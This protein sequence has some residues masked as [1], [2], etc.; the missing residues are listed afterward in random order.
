MFLDKI[1]N[2]Q[3]E[4]IQGINYLKRSE[5]PLVL[6]GTDIFADS[7]RK[8]LLHNKITVDHVVVNEEY[9]IP[10]SFF[11]DHKIE[12]LKDLLNLYPKVNLVIAS[13]A[14][15]KGLSVELSQNSFIN[16]YFFYDPTMF[17]FDFDDYYNIV[18]EYAPTLENFYLQLADDHSR[19][20]MIAFINTK[21]SGNPDSLVSLNIDGE[22]QYFPEFLQLREDE[23]FVDCGAFDG[24]TILDFINKTKGK[25]S[26]IYAFEPDKINIEKLEQ[27]ISPFKNI[28]IIEK[29]CFS[30]RNTLRFQDNEGISSSISNQ[31]NVIIEV[32]AI[33]NI[34]SG[35]VTYI[36]MDIEGSELEALKGAQKTIRTNLPRL[37]VSLYH[38]T[39][40]FFSIPQYIYE[41]NDSYQFYLR[42]YG[43]SSCELV[44][45]AIPYEK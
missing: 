38:R 31:G 24:D 11:Y 8:L 3:Y 29:G 22:Q 34:V 43:L 2:V 33:D 45:Y 36:K 6:W 4:I 37:A 1:V 42:H 5:L 12:R 21:I 32:D 25:Y 16:R 10:D 20:L 39:D 35:K 27:T 7:A 28:E 26:K 44:L 14:N 40:D 30:R 17:E 13:S 15:Y 19:N 9:F 18:N 23:V 41:L